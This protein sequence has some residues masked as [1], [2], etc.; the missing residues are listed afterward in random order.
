M[1]DARS[2]ARRP[3]PAV[4]GQLDGDVTDARFQTYGVTMPSILLMFLLA[5]SDMHIEPPPAWTLQ[6]Q[7]DA[8]VSIASCGGSGVA[9][10]GGLVLTA[11]HVAC[12][13][14]TVEWRD[15]NHDLAL[16][17]TDLHGAYAVLDTAAVGDAVCIEVA[18]P[19]RERQCGHVIDIN[20]VGTPHGVVDLWL[21]IMTVPGNSGAAVYDDGGHLI[22]VI[23]SGVDGIGLAS[24]VF[25]RLPR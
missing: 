25:G 23:T 3:R 13:E 14:S 18:L 12:V 11:S 15:N 4:P 22:G 6:Q 21:D 2:V 19:A 8:T 17:G 16:L 1:L 7:H 20:P 24:S 10:G 5:C 9:I